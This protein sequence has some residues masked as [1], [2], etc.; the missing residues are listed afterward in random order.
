MGH[1]DEHDLLD[2]LGRWAEHGLLSAEQAG[3]IAAHEGVDRTA[4]APPPRGVSGGVLLQYAGSLVALG[5]VFGL[6]FTVLD[7]MS[8]WSRFGVMAAVAAGWTALAGLLGR[9]TGGAAA[10]DAL[11]FSAAVLWYA[12]SLQAFAAIGWLGNGATPGEMRVTF[13]VT[14]AAGAAAGYLAARRVPAPLA[15]L[16]VPIAIAWGSG[17]IGWWAGNTDENAPGTAGAQVIVVAGLVLAA[18]AFTEGTLRLDRI[19]RTWWQIGALG[20]AN[21]AAVVLAVGEGGA[22]EGL[23]FAYAV[24]LAVAA[25]AAR[26]RVAVAFAALTLYEYIGIVVFRTFEG[27]MAAIIILALVGLGT[28]LG[29]T[30]AQRGGWRRLRLG[31]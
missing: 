21:V 19:A 27:A 31:R 30:A 18:L 16:G 25:V 11:G 20:A 7:D 22:Y 17:A 6:Y 14:S 23:L 1:L 9:A 8:D 2:S 12:A 29:G 5:A 13:F 26:Q 3:A 28:A 10:A 24:G 15:A 4:P